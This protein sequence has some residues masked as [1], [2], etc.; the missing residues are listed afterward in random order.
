[1]SFRQT[2]PFNA[3]NSTE[4]SF[5]STE[6]VVNLLALE[7]T[8][9]GRVFQAPNGRA[10]RF[11]ERAGVDYYIALGSSDIVA[12]SSG[13]Q[14]MLGG[15]VEV[16]RA[17]PSDSHVSILSESSSTAAEVNVTLGYGQ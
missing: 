8:A 1:M 14:L 16:K 10:L 15:T 4:P 13:N 7:S 12:T 6:L 5:N 11:A 2:Y 9:I 3:V 17:R